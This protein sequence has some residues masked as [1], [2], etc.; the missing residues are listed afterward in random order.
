MQR[1]GELE[2]CI[3]ERDNL[4]TDLQGNE[5]A[6]NAEIAARQAQRDEEQKAAAEKVAL[7]QAVE[8]KFADAFTALSAD[9]LQ[10]NNGQFLDLAQQAFERSQEA[11]KG[12]LARRQQAID[13]NLE[14]QQHAIN[15]VVSPVRDSLRE[16]G[17][18]VSELEV[19]RET[20]YTELQTQIR[21]L[22]EGQ[23]R[24]QTETA[25]LVTALRSP[26]TRGRWGEL[27]LRNVVEMA[28]MLQGYDFELQ[29]S[30]ATEDGVLRPD[31]IVRLPGQRTVVV[32][33]KVPLEA[34]LN[35]MDATDAETRSHYLRGHARQVREH[36]TRLSEKRY[37]EQFPSSPEFV[38][39]FLPGE[40]F[41]SVALEHDKELIEVGAKKKVILA[42]PTTLVALLRV[43][44]HGFQQERIAQNAEEIGSLGRELYKRL[45]T[46]A[47]HWTKVGRSLEGATKAYNEATGSLDSR[48]FTQARRFEKLGASEHGMELPELAQVSLLPRVSHAPEIQDVADGD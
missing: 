23:S 7:L 11:A 27:Q 36:I 5:I 18:K 13:G 45:C 35:A 20:A 28:G 42:T 8:R 44:Q 15:T 4:I 41:F 25:N 12:E 32:D 14:R 37:W 47:E 38:I 3:T 40:A 21:A 31:M 9:A 22:Q 19:K 29:E 30:V 39:L 6:L 24:L 17:T 43:V 33:S 16:F 26:A 46:L 1:I 10:K 34:Y 48:V 2:Q